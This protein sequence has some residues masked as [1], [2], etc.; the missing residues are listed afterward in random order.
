MMKQPVKTGIRVDTALAVTLD[1]MLRIPQS[2]LA[3]S[4]ANSTLAAFLTTLAGAC[5]TEAQQ[6][7]VSEIVK[8]W[9][10]CQDAEQQYA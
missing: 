4:T 5:L 3:A 7:Q 10:E 1:T 9:Q 2:P 8:R 6:E